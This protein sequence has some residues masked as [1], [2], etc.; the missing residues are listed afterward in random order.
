[1]T[2]RIILPAE[3]TTPQRI[4]GWGFILIVEK[5]GLGLKEVRK[6]VVVLVVCIESSIRGSSVDLSWRK[7]PAEFAERQ[8]L[9]SPVLD[10]CK[11]LPPFI[12]PSFTRPNLPKDA[13]LMRI[14]N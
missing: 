10:P 6:S 9:G 13:C 11:Q 12:L 5:E 2:A 14:E 3:T 1:M 8:H 7:I 4:F